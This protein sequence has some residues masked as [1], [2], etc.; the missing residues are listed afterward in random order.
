MS[1]WRWLAGRRRAE[2]D[3][4]REIDAHVAERADDLM[5]QGLSA[6][7]AQAQARREF[8]NRTLSIERSREVWIAPWLS[9]VW[10]DLRYAVRSIVRQ[11]GFAVSTIA[12]L[13]LGI[14]P[15]AALFTMFNGS[16]LRPWPVRDPSSIAIVKPIPGPREQYGSLSNVEYRYLRDQSRTFTHL[17]AAL[18]GGGPVV[19][20]KTRINVQSNFVSANYFNMLGVG[21]HIGRGFLPEEEDYTSPRAVA[22]ISERLW[23]EHFG[24]SASIIGETIL[25]YDSP[26][27]IVGVAQAGFFDIERNLRRDLWMPRPSLALVFGDRDQN[28]KTLAD[29][30]AGSDFVA[31]RLAPGV[32]RAAAKAELDVLSGQF[33]RTIPMDAHGFTLRSTRPIT[34]DRGLVS[35]QLSTL[36]VAFGALALVMLLV[37]ANVGNLILARGLSRQREL[38][39]RLS[40]GASRMRVVRQLVTEAL[41]WSMLAGVAGL[42]AGIFALRVFIQTTFHNPM[43]ANPDPYVADPAV[44]AFTIAMALVA[45]VTSSL[46]PAL[47]STRVSIAA[48]TAENSAGRT[49]AGRLRTTLLAAQL[50]L[51]MVLLV[52]AGL[53][54]RAVGHALTVDP[55]FAIHEVQAIAIRLPDGASA[56]RST[57]FHRALRDGLE[58]GNPPPIARSQFTAITGSQVLGTFRGGGDAGRSRQLIVRDV[59]ARYF[60]V[61]GIPIVNGRTLADDERVQEVVVNES[62][63]RALWPEDDALGQRLVSGRS[64]AAVSYTVVGVAKDVPV[65]SLTEIQPVVYR[66][67]QSGGLLLVRDLSPAVVD[68]I[69]SSAR[70]IEP[71]A[72]LTARP[73]ADDITVATQGTVMASRLAWAIGLLA[74]ILATVGAFG[75]FAYTVEERRREIGVRMALGAGAR[76]LVATVIA[77]ARTPILL[78][79]GAGLLLAFA[80]APVLGRFLYGLSP[81]DPVAYAGISTMLVV[82]ALVAT[83]IPARRAARIDPAITLRGD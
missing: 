3:L 34:S 30:R 38:A 40:L 37:C 32:S 10:Q 17:A 27:T 63:A 74:L 52:G 23:R 77:G 65:T 2:Q 66:S 57:T 43:L 21:M 47:R 16:L 64:D 8:G 50:A 44:S 54:T 71:E 69:A 7:D 1:A 42:G 28:L 29:P 5:E 60:E 41:L 18:P 72:V 56:D 81:F 53:L 35:N 14:G 6:A 24:A 9:S 49:G 20:G 36:P 75:V 15:L 22:I 33:R 70:S 61:L 45:C 83:W 59:S 62:A 82:S 79:L 78:G 67:I 51:S 11:P 4:A 58:A 48:R 13:A 25:V 68:R 19:Y 39:I 55:G 46:L 73:L 80:A 26:F 31:G 12:I 76:Q